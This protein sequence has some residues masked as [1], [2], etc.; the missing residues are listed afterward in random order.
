MAK[1]KKQKKKTLFERIE[2]FTHKN[3][4]II[5]LISVAVSFILSLILFNPDVSIGGDDSMYIKSAFNFRHGIAFPSWHGSIYSIVLSVFIFVFGLNLII[6]KLISVVFS[7]LSLVFIQKALLKISNYTVSAIV[8]LA[9]SLSL[10]LNIYASTTYTEPFFIFLQSLY[11]YLF[12]NYITT[13]NPSGSAWKKMLIFS[14]I[15]YLMFQTRTVALAVVGAT[16]IYLLFE[17]QFRNSA[18]Y[19]IFIALLHSIFTLYKKLFWEI[20]HTG[21]EH[22]LETLLLKHPYKPY[23]G[24]ENIM[25]FIQRIWDNSELY[26]SKHLMKMTGFKA[27]ESR[28]TNTILAIILLIVIFLSAILVIKKNKKALFLILY[29]VSIIGLTFISLQKIWDQDRLIII[30]FPYILGIVFLGLWYLFQLKKLAKFQF[31]PLIL[32]LILLFSISK[33]TVEGFKDYSHNNRFKSG[34]FNSYNT[35]WQNYMKAARWT[36]QN[37]SDTAVVACRKPGMAWISSKGVDI[38]KGIYNI[39]YENA[40]SIIKTFEN[41]GATHVIMANL[42]LDPRRKTVKTI[43]TIRKSLT[44]ISYKSPG[45]FELIKEFGIDEKAYLFKINFKNKNKE[46]VLKNLDSDMIIS[47]KNTNSYFMKGRFYYKNKQYEEA[48]KYYK[49]PLT[50]LKNDAKIYYNIALCYYSMQDFEN[51]SE[52]I[53]ESIKYKKDD[54]DSWFYL[55]ICYFNMQKIPEAKNAF[56]IAKR[57][58]LKK[59]SSKF[60]AVLAKYN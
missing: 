38:F 49:Y 35:D 11:I 13:N 9:T 14:I 47:P 48:L 53:I 60:E 52:N 43:N 34:E 58:G 27:I 25:G 3:S 23:E 15:S 16:I 50:Y 24:K 55:S 12:I 42:R 36:S 5:L 8:V 44:Y 33:Q 7:V 20:K 57:N 29:L 10:L 22:Q 18:L 51:A 56:S 4:K 1:N 54:P 59:D 39:E 31:L 19:L 30:Y 32:S 2:I 45:S 46:E 17:K 6:L 26:L 28:E 40:D 41:I 37:L 21:F